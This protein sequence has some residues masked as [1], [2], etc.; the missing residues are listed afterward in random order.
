MKTF[1]LDDIEVLTEQEF[2]SFPYIKE[3]NPWTTIVLPVKVDSSPVR[4]DDPL[5][6]FVRRWS[7][8]PALVFKALSEAKKAVFKILAGAALIAIG[9]TLTYYTSG[10]G[11]I[12]GKA[13]IATGIGL[14]VGGMIDLLFPFKL[15]SFGLAQEDETRTYT[16]GPISNT[17]GQGALIPPIYGTHIVGGSVIAVFTRPRG[18][19]GNWTRP[20]S[21]TGQGTQTGTDNV[22]RF[23]VSIDEDITGFEATFIAS[24]DQPVLGNWGFWYKKKTDST[25]TFLGWGDVQ[26]NEPTSFTEWN[27][28]QTQYDLGVSLHYHY[29]YSALPT[30]NFNWARVFGKTT[31]QEQKKNTATITISGSGVQGLTTASV[32]DWR[33][34][35]TH[36]AGIGT[37][38]Q[39]VFTSSTTQKVEYTFPDEPEEALILLAVGEGEIGY[40]SNYLV[41]NQ[42]IAN[43]HQIFVEQRTGKDVQSV[44]EEFQDVRTVQ[45]VGSG[46]V[47][48]TP[49]TVTTNSPVDSVELVFFF[50]QGLFKVENDGRFT[51]L[52]VKIK[53]EFK[54]TTDVTW[55]F[56][57]EVTFTDKRRARL[58]KRVYIPQS[59]LGTPQEK[60]DIRV[61][62]MTEDHKGSKKFSDVDFQEM[63]LV[64]DMRLSY[65]NTAL[66]AVRVLA[67]EQV[68]GALPTINAL[69]K[70]KLCKVPHLQV[71]NAT[72]E[73]SD[74][75]WDPVQ[76]TY[77]RF[78]DDAVAVDTGQYIY[79]WT[80]NPVWH[81]YDLLT[82]TRYGA[83]AFLDPQK[84]LDIEQ[85]K[86]EAKFCDELVNVKSDGSIKERRFEQDRVV[87]N[88]RKVWDILAEMANTFQGA[89]INAG[90]VY[91]V[92][93]DRPVQR[94]NILT[95]S[96]TVAEGGLSS[97]K[98]GFLSLGQQFNALNLQYADR[99]EQ[100]QLVT[101][102]VEDQQAVSS[103][104]PHLTVKQ[105]NMIGVSR[106]SQ[107]ER[108]ARKELNFI[109][110]IKSTAEATCGW[111]LLGAEVFDRIGVQSY[112]TKWG[113][114]EQAEG[115]K[116]RA[117]TSPRTVHLDM[118]VSF[119][120]SNTYEMI[121][122]HS[123]TGTIETHD[124]DPVTGETDTVTIVSTASFA[125]T[126]QA[127]DVV[128]IGVKAAS[129]KDYRI[130]S[131]SKTP[132]GT[133]KVTLIEYNDNVL[134]DAVPQEDF[135]RNR[136]QL[137][138]GVIPPFVEEF[139]AI[140]LGGRN[141]EVVLSW[142]KPEDPNF[143][144][145]DL[146]RS[147][148]GGLTFNFIGNTSNTIWHDPDRQAGVLY[149][150]IAQS[151]SITGVRSG[152]MLSPRV[153]IIPQAP[154]PP[155][156]VTGLVLFRDYKDRTSA[157]PHNRIF[158]G[159][160]ALFAWNRVART[161][162]ADV[163]EPSAD[164]DGIPAGCTADDDF[165]DFEVRILN[166]DGTERRTL[167]LKDP[168]FL[169]TF[170]M[171]VEDGN[172]TPARQFTITVAVRDIHGGISPVQAKLSVSNP[173][174]LPPSG[175]TAQA[176][177]T[178]VLISFVRPMD[179]P[180]LAGFSVHRSTTPNFT[181]TDATEV[182][183]GTDNHIDIP[184][185]IG[186]AYYFKVASFDTFGATI[187]N[188]IFTSEVTA[189]PVGVDPQSL[190]D[191]ISALQLNTGRVELTG[192][193][194]TDDSPS[195]GSV[196][197]SGMT[198]VLDGTSYSITD[199]NTS[200]RW[201]YWTKGNTTLS[202]SATTFPS[203]TRND[204]LIAWNDNGTLK[205][206][207]NSSLHQG[208]LTSNMLA[209]DFVLT[210]ESQIGN[211]IINTA[212]IKDAAIT[213]AKIGQLQVGNSH[214][215]DQAV[216][217]LKLADGAVVA[218]KIA[219][220]AVGQ[221]A[222]ADLAVTEAKIANAA[223]TQTKIQDAAIVDAKIVNLHASKI[224]GG[225]ITADKF[226]STL[227]G[228]LN[229][230][231]S[232]V[233]FML[234]GSTDVVNTL[235]HND[236]GIGAFTSAYLR[237][238]END[239]SDVVVSP[240]TAT[241]WD[242]AGATWD[243]AGQKWDE[244]IV[245]TLT[246]W[247]S[248]ESLMDLGSNFTGRA[249]FHAEKLIENAGTGTKIFTVKVT[250]QTNGS[251]TWG[252]NEPT[253]NDG[254]YETLSENGIVSGNTT[255]WTGLIRT[256]VRKIRY[257]VEM[258][259][260]VAADRIW[261]INPILMFSDPRVGS[262]LTSFDTQTTVGGGG[263]APALPSNPVGYL[264][265]SIKD[266]TQVAVPYYTK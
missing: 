148:D 170:D 119:S 23:V 190:N 78:S 155:P 228:D 75:Y 264:I 164:I 89:L 223:I 118:P 90:S 205:P 194:W 126:P 105:V 32:A 178:S 199:G 28:A 45:P 84:D 121:L 92:K 103:T 143:A 41:N 106:R 27:L 172:G 116:V 152:L 123:A 76:G 254:G 252:T 66:L 218:A 260:S 183:R 26:N 47:F 186:Q 113:A 259:T 234:S 77:K 79:Q 195:P 7:H 141:R 131:I 244:D 231:F 198:I 142:V 61:T 145:V 237:H 31:Q 63:V 71:N 157:S 202:T 210:K 159:P 6:F 91:Q 68:S 257:K 18:F 29:K 168:E 192:E 30:V 139:T 13:L 213:S 10:I 85:F 232:Y 110:Y 49:V 42:P 130:M 15:P 224:Y 97:F 11:A 129:V 101:L 112:Y 115:V 239:I 109:K 87:D 2:S 149:V 46:L 261:M 124:L 191:T 59:R 255:G 200:D 204:F 169:Y 137:P 211:A 248:S 56:F 236:V 88:Q 262:T 226:V 171:N 39:W 185:L 173:V 82:N 215:A 266:G 229:Q 25:W 51:D 57:N 44:I 81:V 134:V 69:A 177:E 196:A 24:F 96:T 98:G 73:Y 181:P 22:T 8:P 99:L 33:L 95:S 240:V 206:L 67:N 80:S 246:S 128:I 122:R 48:N 38:K 216:N 104:Q 214:L 150:Y 55:T 179:I 243:G 3:I 165:M 144:S 201:I 35:L 133:C 161:C 1:T 256:A 111:D 263:S 12:F 34:K 253:Y 120:G 19:G 108:R 207:W 208:I 245:T 235:D 43:F 247:E 221:A 174:P 107:V 114:A 265:V 50:P 94:S 175:L 140:S 16:F 102:P 74:C 220:A 154:T 160:H 189:T 188:L 251:T 147:N 197:W 132:D 250:Y 203:L 53:I 64:T 167:H 153:T 219:T 176:R 65:P 249:E 258:Q 230:A 86:T 17:Q 37:V 158:E 135:S 225:T 209:A 54:K 62:R 242:D 156:L 182:Y 100:F 238:R 5:H 72:I 212:H 136:P 138:G 166:P 241:K 125:E 180:D 40:L 127:G 193:T 36:E 70:G 184:G 163:D 222:I 14:V 60:Y 227:Q 21:V 233:D 217:D 9:L 187:S 4:D 83:G 162:G 146:Y 93:V 20:V 58:K 117:F 52:S 151:V